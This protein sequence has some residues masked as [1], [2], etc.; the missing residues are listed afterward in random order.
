MNAKQNKQVA[1]VTGA[2]GGVGAHIVLAL[3]EAGYHVRA[4]D[5]L[6]QPDFLPAHEHLQWQRVDLTRGSSLAHVVE[7]VDVLVHAAARVTL[8]ESYDDFLPINVHVTAR[9]FDAA[10]AQGVAHFV[11]I[12][13]AS[14]YAASK[15]MLDESS[16]VEVTTGYTQ[17]KRDAELVFTAR[18]GCPWTIL[19]PQMIYG[20]F[21]TRMS[22]GMV[23]LPPILRHFIPYLP[24][25]TG[26]PRTNWCHA[27]DVAQAVLTVLG[28]TKSIGQVYNV[29]D[30]TPLGF[31]EVMTAM[32]EAYGL[33]VGPLIPFPGAG[34]QTMAGP[35]IDR[36]IVFDTLRTTLR[37]L[38]KRVLATHGLT[39]PLR[40]RIDRK[41]LVFTSADLI[42]GS[43][44]LRALG[45]A[46]KW[47]DFRQGI[48]ET[49][50]WYQH[51]QWLPC[52]DTQSLIDVRQRERVRGF[53]FNE[54]LA[55]H[56]MDSQGVAHEMKLD[57]DVQFPQV[58]QLAT[59][60]NGTIDG[61]IWMRGLAA[62]VPVVGTIGL[63]WLSSRKKLV[64]EFAF[65]GDEDI[66]YR[67]YGEKSVNLR[68][69][70]ESM[71]V[72]TGKVYN[73]RG[74]CVGE[75]EL[76]YKLSRQIV[77]FLVSL[78]FLLTPFEGAA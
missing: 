27:E 47:P 31:G 72:L 42:V 25:L 35:V 29:A 58:R 24:G 21:C 70:I 64:Y 54:T 32:T 23:T 20:P 9:L 16:A 49:V 5:K 59:K 62:Y 44:A 61:T 68:H 22:A 38:W 46:P 39:S 3:L 30:Q 67:F 41:A 73:P 37:E 51:Q 33:E 55:G 2:A 63:S 48:V 36:D 13:C 56:W 77:P 65:E 76:G 26:G 43:Q 45:W 75:V 40:P 6:A 78:R 34:L 1:L 11:H 28:T 15:A 10:S 19:R 57:L 71:E 18:D 53:A 66:T 52:Y 50:R 60:I 7:G 4:L 69:P 14:L 8:T 17:S 74:E 12:S